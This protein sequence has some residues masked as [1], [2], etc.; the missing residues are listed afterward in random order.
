MNYLKAQKCCW[1]KVKSLFHTKRK[2]T[3]LLLKTKATCFAHLLSPADWKLWT[4]KKPAG[5]KCDYFYKEK[6]SLKALRSTLVEHQYYRTATLTVASFKVFQLLYIESQWP[7]FGALSHMFLEIICQNILFYEFYIWKLQ[8]FPGK[9]NTLL[10]L[11]I[12]NFIGSQ[13]VC[14]SNTGSPWFMTICSVTIRIYDCTEQR[15]LWPC[16]KLLTTHTWSYSYCQIP[17]SYDKIWVLNTLMT[18]RA[19]QL[20]PLA[21]LPSDLSCPPS[22]LTRKMAIAQEVSLPS[23]LPIQ[24][25]KHPRAK[26]THHPASR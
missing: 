6:K 9:M 8:N 17:W 16:L 2:S 3:H 1:K 23:P 15:D 24:P 4:T 12:G 18:S 14:M 22:W 25:T 10:E 13:I 26:K 11:D 5:Y 19:V 20:P 7:F 21:Y